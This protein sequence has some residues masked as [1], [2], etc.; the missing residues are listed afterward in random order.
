MLVVSDTTPIISLRKAGKLNLLK[1]L[2]GEVFI[3]R[4]VYCEITCNPATDEKEITAIA[5]NQFLRV[6]EVENQLAVYLLREQMKL[7]AGESEAIVLAESIQADLMLIDEKKARRITKEMG[8]SITGT[9]G[10]LLCAKNAGYIINIKPI[11]DKMTEQKFHISD[12]LYNEELELVNE[13]K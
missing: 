5:D 7:G 11:L 4:A 1:E 10:L 6:I 3:P 12:R 9:I 8:I 2:F 13:N